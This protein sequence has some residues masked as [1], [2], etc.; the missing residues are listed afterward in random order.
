MIDYAYLETTNYCNLDCS[1]CNRADVIGP[2]NHISLDKWDTLLDKI[3][4]QPLRITKLMGMGEPFLHPQFD[5]VV[6]K[7]KKVFPSTQVI[8]A[9]NCQYDIRPSSRMGIKFRNALGFIDQLYLSIDGFEANYERDRAP[10]KWSKLINFLDHLKDIDRKGCNIVVNY[11]VNAYNVEDIAR[12]DSLREEYN[13]GKLRL[14]MV[15]LWDP[16]KN[17]K[18]NTDTSLYTQEDLAYLKANWQNNI[19]GKSVWDYSDCFWPKSGLYTTVEGHVK[20]CCMNTAAEPI[21]NLFEEDLEDILAK[22]TY[23]DIK[24]GCAT[25]KPADHCKTCSYKQLI[26]LLNMLGPLQDD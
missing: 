25:N 23:Q 22:Q 18:D 12:I 14:N 3:K 6:E 5:K 2:L 16:D 26:P 10:A 8:V 1:F 21:G 4:D 15:Q 13:L 20:V 17:L 19:M 7:F 24:G 11:V 9:T